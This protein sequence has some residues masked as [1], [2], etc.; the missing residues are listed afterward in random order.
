MPYRIVRSG[1]K[2]QVKKYLSGKV[3]GTHETRQEAQDQIT[4]IKASEESKR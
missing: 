4:A 2:W 3:L 1:G